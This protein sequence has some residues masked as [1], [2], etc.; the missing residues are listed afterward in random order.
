M[1]KEQ[2]MMFLCARVLAMMAVA[3][4]GVAASEVDEMNAYASGCLRPGYTVVDMQIGGKPGEVI[5][6]LVTPDRRAHDLRRMWRPASER[7]GRVNQ[8]LMAALRGYKLGGGPPGSLGMLLT[9]LL[10][11]PYST[12]GLRT[13]R[14]YSSRDTPS[15]TVWTAQVRRRDGKYR[16]LGPV[17]SYE[18]TLNQEGEITDLRKILVETDSPT[19][20]AKPSE[21]ERPNSKAWWRFW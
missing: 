20:P 5:Y 12:A 11:G 15:G 16:D 2:Y 3:P 17:C 18:I 6:L 14:S 8:H 10:D 7:D 19:A 4:A 9:A 21:P 13:S 1:G